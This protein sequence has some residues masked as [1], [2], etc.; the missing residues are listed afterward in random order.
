MENY[1]TRTEYVAVAAGALIVG[2][3]K[4][5]SAEQLAKGSTINLFSWIHNKI[6]RAD[7]TPN[8]RRFIAEIA[9]DSMLDLVESYK[10]KNAIMQIATFIES[11][12]FSFENEI[13]EFYG[14]E[15]MVRLCRFT[16]KQAV[17]NV[18]DSYSLSDSL[19]DNI[20]KIIFDRLK[21]AKFE[22]NLGIIQ[23]D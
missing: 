23:N 4:N 13:R 1:T 7:L 14:D 21:T 3:I 6:H 15:Y 2:L 10:D 9:R 5:M 8:E 20:R 17:G 12:S 11:L 16:E 19:R 22:Q 18:E